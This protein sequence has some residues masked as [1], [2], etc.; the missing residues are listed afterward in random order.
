MGRDE[1]SLLPPSP[2]NA[3]R[4]RLYGII[5]VVTLF[6]LLLS[7][8]SAPISEVEIDWVPKFTK[9]RPSSS[10]AN[11]ASKE[12]VV[13][14]VGRHTGTIIFLHGLGG[15]PEMCMQLVNNIRPR[16]HQI[17]WRLP[18]AGLIPVTANR[19]MPMSAWFNMNSL[20]VLGDDKLP[21]DDDEKGLH[22]G[23]KRVH[24]I[25]AGE[26][27]M[28]IDAKRIVI[29]G[30]SQGCAIAL[31]AALSSTEEIGG[32]MCLSGWLPLANKWDVINGTRMHEMQ[33]DNAAD[34]DVWW[35]HG[36]DDKTVPLG[37]GEKSAKELKELGFGSINFNTYEGLRHWINGKEQE[38]MGDWLVQR[39]GIV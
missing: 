20:E 35:G 32:V 21:P 17:S 37:W 39:L 26:L 8:R 24:D 13:D 22:I 29:A 4:A 1:L 6:L 36:V 10:H 34:T 3:T 2:P 27:K 14:G 11:S 5:A 12:L 30:F 9:Q 25:I 19:G 16:L 18:N 15:T 31:L 28:G 23:V 38:D 7:T 33:T